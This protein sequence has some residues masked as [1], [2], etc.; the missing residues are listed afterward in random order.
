[1]AFALFDRGMI[2]LTFVHLVM[3]LSLQRALTKLVRWLTHQALPQV[4]T[5]ILYWMFLIVVAADI[6]PTVIVMLSY[7]FAF[8]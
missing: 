1:M 6:I 3:S 8:A 4:R 5:S 2:M 7:L